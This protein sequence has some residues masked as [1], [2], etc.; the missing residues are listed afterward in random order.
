MNYSNA[1]NENNIN[2]KDNQDL[3]QVPDSPE[4]D[5]KR[6]LNPAMVVE[7]TLPKQ[8][9]E[10][11]EDLTQL[12]DKFQGI[13]LQNKYDCEIF[14]STGSTASPSFSEIT[15]FPTGLKLLNCTHIPSKAKGN[16]LYQQTKVL[17]LQDAGSFR[18]LGL[19][20]L[21]FTSETLLKRCT[22]DLI[23]ET[24]K[25]LALIIGIGKS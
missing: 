22:P 8:N 11:W 2:V 25:H 5:L 14:S 6:L 15:L 20:S 17:Q 1:N 21:M 23:Q 19:S 18:E 7:D 13:F 9:R 4:A 10:Q 3:D 12:L 16:Y 24:C